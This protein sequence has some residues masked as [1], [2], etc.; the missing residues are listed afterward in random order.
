MIKDDLLFHITTRK[1]WK[2]SNKDGRYLPESLDTEGFIHASRGEQLEDTA[3]RLFSDRN[4]ILL[5]VIETSRLAPEVKFEEDP[6]SG[7]KFPHIY[8]PLNM[9]AI[10]DKIEVYAE[11]NGRFK[12]DFTSD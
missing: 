6:D 9:D 4:K 7:E 12:I 11:K 10:V 8:G 3:N 1:Q 2:E 5:L